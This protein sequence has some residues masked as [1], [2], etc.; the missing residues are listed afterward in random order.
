MEEEEEEEV[1]VVCLEVLWAQARNLSV[2]C[3]PSAGV[4]AAGRPTIGTKRDAKKL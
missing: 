2:W 4:A 3:C 1:V